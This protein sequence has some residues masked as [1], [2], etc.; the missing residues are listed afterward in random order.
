MNCYACH[1]TPCS[2]IFENFENGSDEDVFVSVRTP[3][4]G[5]LVDYPRR[6]HKAP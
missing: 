6:N 1:T 4:L 3:D 5:A 2:E